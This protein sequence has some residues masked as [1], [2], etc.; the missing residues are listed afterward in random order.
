MTVSRDDL[1]E[2]AR[3]LIPY[4][5]DARAESGN[6]ATGSAES[7]ITR[8][9]FPPRALRVEESARS[10]TDA[11]WNEKYF[12][13]LVA[14]TLMD[15]DEYGDHNWEE[16]TIPP[17]EMIDEIASDVSVSAF[18]EELFEWARR[19]PDWSDVAEELR[20]VDSADGEMELEL[21]QE[22]MGD[23]IYRIRRAIIQEMYEQLLEE[24]GES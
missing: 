18:Y 6:P 19:S 20:T 21:M 16:D 24:E 23:D 12:Y 9:D 22:G 14:E 13:G 11:S 8:E 15:V 5:Q 17:E 2:R 1:Q 7:D 4:F 10:E 3:K